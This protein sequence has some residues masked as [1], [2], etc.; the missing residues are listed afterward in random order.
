MSVPA[1][2]VQDRST[3]TKWA[4][5]VTDGQINITSSS[6]IA[7]SDPIV[8]DLFVT[9]NY[10]KIFVDD[11]VIGWEA[12]ATV[13]DDSI[14]L[15]DATDS[16]VYRLGVYD[17]QLL[18]LVISTPPTPGGSYILTDRT[19]ATKWAI[20]IADGQLAI[21][22]SFESA[23]AEPIFQDRQVTSQYWKLFVNNGTLGWE[24]TATIQ[25]DA[26]NIEDSVTL[27]NYLLTII[28]GQFNWLLIPTDT[29]VQGERYIVQ[30]R[31]SVK[32]WAIKISDGELFISE[33]FDNASSEPIV[34]DRQNTTNYWKIFVA[35][36]QLGWEATLT[37]R[38]D[39]IDLEDLSNDNVYRLGV[40][41][42]QFM[43]YLFTSSTSPVT[44]LQVGQWVIQDR[45]TATKWAVKVR[46]GQLYWES[47]TDDVDGELT[48]QDLFDPLKYWRLFINDGELAWE[49]TFSSLPEYEV[50]IRDSVD[51]V[52][53]RLEVYD[54]Q[55]R[56]FGLAQII[57]EAPDS[58]LPRT[59]FTVEL[60]DRNFD[61]IKIITPFISSLSWEFSSI[62]GCGRLTMS[63][64]L[65][66]QNIEQ[67]VAPDY[68]VRVN[69]WN[70][71]TRTDVLFYRGF[72]E[73][74]QPIDGAKA[75]VSLSAAGY[76]N[77]LK[78]L[79]VNQTYQDA[80]VSTIVKDIL[81]SFVT[82][83]TNITYDAADI[84]TVGYSIDQISFDT[85]AEKAL[86]TL[87]DIA[88]GFEY[89]V[90]RNLKFF[91]KR[92]S[93]NIENTV[94]VKKDL[95]RYDEIN[96]FAAI[97]NRL[98][99]KGGNGFNDVVNNTESQN[100]YGLRE[101]I[102][103]NSAII[104]SAT[105]QRWGSGVLSEE[106][107]IRRRLK[108]SQV[109]NSRLV[110]SILPLG[111]VAVIREPVSVAKRYG[112][113]DAIYGRIKYGG[114]ASYTIE[115]INYKMNSGGIDIDFDL[116]QPRPDIA[117]HLKQLEFELSQI[118]NN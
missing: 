57:A 92:R 75:S 73:K 56:W 111:R 103:S 21:S 70:S 54:S 9:S 18:T 82:N 83:A 88:N 74:F 107:R 95:E 96:D 37:V 38:N 62:G 8:R 50:R 91:F 71:V 106:A 2:I 68:E 105:A 60:R 100:A 114:L 39:Q 112:D 53:Y 93:T 29:G 24:S 16:S 25:N 32:K 27:D 28:D 31:D 61:L 72:L 34:Q 17:A 67:F 86:Q 14:D 55:F 58:Q 66:G 80:E 7:S 13:Q 11:G 46:D 5:A 49:Q 52:M 87:G 63:L 101:K 110:E 30:D 69:I 44:V 45:T 23:S 118:R 94:K 102:V 48:M 76:F 26:I 4:I 90:D 117:L 78:R 40:V 64:A 79:R 3:A 109:P 33:T 116:G 41:D 43:W 99:L 10:W 12:T 51:N 65:E 81:D 89:G 115:K 108:V 36:G 98:I 1:Y 47:T 42:G 20:T 15:E 77:K 104:T 84:D 113:S 19:T 97:Y 59:Q 35:D 6:D 22:E 85:T